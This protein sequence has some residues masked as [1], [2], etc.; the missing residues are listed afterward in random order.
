MNK[1]YPKKKS[2]H[3]VTLTLRKFE[4]EILCNIEAKNYEIFKYLNT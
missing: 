3:R 2:G 1:A 4:I